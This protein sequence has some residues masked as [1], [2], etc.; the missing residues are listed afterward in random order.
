MCARAR[1]RVYPKLIPN[2]HVIIIKI[3]ISNYINPN[4]D[5]RAHIGIVRQR[6]AMHRAE[7]AVLVL[8]ASLCA[9]LGRERQPSLWS[10]SLFALLKYD[11]AS[12]Q[13]A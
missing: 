10:L 2:R 7:C 13:G 3:K 1:V 5:R 9:S 6:G 4:S 8:A 12:G 11:L